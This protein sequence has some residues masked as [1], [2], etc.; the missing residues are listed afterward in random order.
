MSN[1]T[2][3]IDDSLLKS[4]RQYAQKHHTSLNALI[5]KLL[6]ET[7]IPD[8]QNWLEDCYKLMDSSKVNSHGEKWSRE[9]LYDV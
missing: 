9:E 4:G 3:S 2:I 5:R 1:L 8:N 6:Q 7:V